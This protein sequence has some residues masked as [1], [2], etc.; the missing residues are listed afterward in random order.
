MSPAIP[1]AF[2]AA[3][4]PIVS[5]NRHAAGDSAR[6]NAKRAFPMAQ[7]VLLAAVQAIILIL[8]GL[9]ASAIGAVQHPRAQHAQ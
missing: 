6:T 8:P 1:A 9:A 5:L 2:T 4:A 3:A 7:L